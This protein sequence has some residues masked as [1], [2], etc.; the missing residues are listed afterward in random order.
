MTRKINALVLLHEKLQRTD[1]ASHMA[2]R[3]SDDRRVPAHDMIARQQGVRARDPETKMIR[4]VTRSVDGFYFPSIAGNPVS[5]CQRHVI[6][7]RND[8]ASPGWSLNAD[9]GIVNF[10][11]H[12]A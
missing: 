6:F 11:R 2:F 4:S 8:E 7:D 9:G 1:I 3:R 10:A 12:S 5:V